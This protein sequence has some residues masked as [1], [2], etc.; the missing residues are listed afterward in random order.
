MSDLVLGFMFGVSLMI[1]VGSFWFEHYLKEQ[2]RERNVQKLQS[3]RKDYPD[4]RPKK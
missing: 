1:L 4:I 3:K 2:R